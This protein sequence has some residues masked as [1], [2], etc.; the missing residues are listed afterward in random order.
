[1]TY[2]DVPKGPGS[3]WYRLR[4][5]HRSIR[6][7]CNNP[8]C[9]DYGSYGARGIRLCPEWE[10]FETFYEWAMT[11]GYRADLT[12]DR[13]NNNKGYEPGNC[14]WVSRRAQANNRTTARRYT[15]DG[16]T[17]S[18]TDWCRLYNIE[19]YVVAHR[20]NDYGWSVSDA[21]KTPKGEKPLSKRRGKDASRVC[22]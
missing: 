7:R 12:I 2:E 19:P 11:H 13:A 17:K 10:D 16:H 15:I 6:K 4:E 3:D 18:L 8:L 5:I 9:K 1:M 20:M 21:V 22:L 14:R